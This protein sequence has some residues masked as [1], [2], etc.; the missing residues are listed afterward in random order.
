MF[1]RFPHL[2]PPMETLSTAHTAATQ[3]ERRCPQPAATRRASVVMLQPRGATRGALVVAG[4][5]MG[6]LSTPVDAAPQQLDHDHDHG[7]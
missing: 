4:D 6:R 3:E 7:C 1:F 2:W 5:V